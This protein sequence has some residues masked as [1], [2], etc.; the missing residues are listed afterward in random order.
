MGRHDQH[1]QYVSA[2]PPHLASIA[3]LA[4]PPEPV[5]L[6]YGTVWSNAALQLI[7]ALV[8][9]FARAHH[10]GLLWM[11]LCLSMLLVCHAFI[12]SL[13]VHGLAIDFPLF[14]T[15]IFT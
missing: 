7:T 1:A 11:L 3:L 13:Y 14:F 12:P 5:V 6:Y 10:H 2:N 4:A 9:C 8:H 15:Y